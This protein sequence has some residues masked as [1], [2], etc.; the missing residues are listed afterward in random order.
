MLIPSILSTF[1]HFHFA[2]RISSLNLI[3]I[4]DGFISIGTA[5]TLQDVLN[6]CENHKVLFS[7]IELRSLDQMIFRLH[8]FGST[9]RR[10]VVS[11]IDNFAFGGAATDIFNFLLSGKAVLSTIKCSQSKLQKVQL[12]ILSLNTE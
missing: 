12:M 3:D 2:G 9:Q 10:K 5:T 6:F 8:Q 11:I 1:K 4:A 7:F